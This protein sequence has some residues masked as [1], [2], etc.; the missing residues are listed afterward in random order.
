M[1]VTRPL[2]F[3]DIR[4]STAASVTTRMIKP[5]RARLS[6]YGPSSVTTKLEAVAPPA[7]L[8]LAA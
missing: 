2:R 7:D 5:M 8:S 3:V 4:A 1:S 6:R